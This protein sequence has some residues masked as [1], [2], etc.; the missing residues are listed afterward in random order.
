MY[1]HGLSIVLLVFML[2]EIGGCLVDLK[3][4]RYF[5]KQNFVRLLVDVSL[6][7]WML[8][9]LWSHA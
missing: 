6:V 4:R 7:I 8:I 9:E 1:S 3:Q 2:C 5:R